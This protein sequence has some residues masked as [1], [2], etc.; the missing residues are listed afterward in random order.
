MFVVMENLQ[1]SCFSHL[2]MRQSL[3]AMMDSAP[4][5]KKGSQT[6]IYIYKDSEATPLTA[7]VMDIMIVWTFLMS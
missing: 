2:V 4:P 3:H 1:E 7:G 6:H 5:S